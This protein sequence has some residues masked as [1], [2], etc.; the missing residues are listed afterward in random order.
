MTAGRMRFNETFRIDEPP[1]RRGLFRRVSYMGLFMMSMTSKYILLTQ[2]ITMLIC[3]ISACLFGRELTEIESIRT[4][5]VQLQMS[6]I[7]TRP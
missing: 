3:S 1:L 5:N 2:I 7:K 6:G 4:K